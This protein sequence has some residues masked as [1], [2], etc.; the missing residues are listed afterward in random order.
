MFSRTS[1]ASKI[2]LAAL[3]CFC[4][5]NG[6]RHIDCQQNTRHLASLGAQEIPRKL[7]LE[8]VEFGLAQPAPVWKFD[9]L[10]WTELLTSKS[11]PT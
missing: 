8:Q 4:R 2:A 7:F 1:N 11:M 9:V 5:K 3:V 6:I 10:Y